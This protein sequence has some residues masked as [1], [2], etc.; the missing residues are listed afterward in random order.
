MNIYIKPVKLNEN[1]KKS[2]ISFYEEYWKINLEAC[3]TVNDGI[4][5]IIK[6]I[7]KDSKSNKN[8]ETK[9]IYSIIDEAGI[10]ILTISRN[11]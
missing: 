1:E 10:S 7:N 4:K 3:L 8:I 2:V 6:Y 9:W 5:N 11:I